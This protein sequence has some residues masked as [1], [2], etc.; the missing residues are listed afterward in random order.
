MMKVV[1]S[2]QKG[3]SKTVL[4]H[5]W[6]EDNQILAKHHLA[7]SVSSRMASFSLFFLQEYLQ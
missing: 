2:K 7:C 6:L 4:A 1:S 5:T 3:A